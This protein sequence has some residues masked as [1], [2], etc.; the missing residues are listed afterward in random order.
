MTELNKMFTVATDSSEDE[1]GP[2]NLI[3]TQSESV[4]LKDMKQIVEDALFKEIMGAGCVLVQLNRDDPALLATNDLESYAVER[5]D[6]ALPDEKILVYDPH[7]GIHLIGLQDAYYSCTLPHKTIVGCS[8]CMTR[9]TSRACSIKQLSTQYCGRKG[10]LTPYQLTEKLKS[11][12]SKISQYTYISPRLT[13]VED[14]SKTFRPVDKHDFSYV[15]ERSN[16]IRD[17]LRERG[18]FNRF[19]KEVCPTCLVHQGCHQVQETR[20]IRWCHGPFA[21]SE[22]EAVKQLLQEYEIPFK[23]R[24]LLYLALNSGKL[25]KR[26]ERCKYWATFRTSVGYHDNKRVSFGLCRYTTGEYTPIPSFKEAKE[27]LEKC[28]NTLGMELHNIRDK[29]K[30]LTP[31]EKALL[32]ELGAHHQSPVNRSRWHATC[33]DFLGLIYDRWGGGWELNFKF[34]SHGGYSSYRPDGLVLPWSISAQN[35]ND[36]FSD[37]TYLKTLRQSDHPL[38]RFK[39]NRG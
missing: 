9:E 13:A 11:R 16:A 32:I 6:T 39:Y 15:T 5:M 28:G 26:Y 19:K 25:E 35:F 12:K 23:P 1:D 34:N 20:D 36:I 22:K 10:G 30:L 27:I 8:E 14:F 3:F 18:R 17:G 37:T 7:R 31:L 33:Y 24:E 4:E 38:S 21:L 2:C 29:H